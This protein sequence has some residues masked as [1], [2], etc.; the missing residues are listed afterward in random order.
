MIKTSAE[1][2][3]EQAFFQLAYGKLQDSLKNLLP[4]LIGFEIV[5]KNDA[6]TKALGVFGF[7]SQSGEILY[8]PAFFVNGKVKN[9]DLL[10][11]KNNEQ[12]Y[13]LTE[14]FAELFLKDDLVDFGGVSQEPRNKVLQDIPQGDFRQMAVPPRTGKYSVASVID[15]VKDSDNKTKQ[16]FKGLIEKDAEFCEA[17]LRFYPLE[18]VAEALVEQP[19]EKKAEE[20]DLKVVSVQ[21]KDEVAKLTPK[22]KETLLTQGFIVID[23]RPTDKKSKFGVVD[24]IKKF[25]N[26]TESGF[27]PYVTKVGTLNYGLILVRPKQLQ[28]NFATDDA[29][30]INLDAK[31]KGMAYLTD[32]SDVFVKDQIKVDDY[33]QVHKMMV[34]PAEAKPSYSNVYILLNEKMKASQPFRINA[35]F[36][37]A[38]GIRRLSVEPYTCYCHSD[39]ENRKGIKD[40]PGSAHDLPRGN[41]YDHPKKC[42]EFLLVMTKK[43]GDELSYGGKTVYVPAGYKLL[44][45]NIDHHFHTAVSAD[46]A[47]N[48]A[49]VK[50]EAA[51]REE[52]ETGK[53]GRLCDLNAFLR[54]KNVFP[55]TVN[56][57]GSEYFV[58]IAGAK[59][60]YD[61]PIKAKIAMTV[62]YGMD[63]K[64][65]SDLIDNLVP[66]K[67]V[68]GH[69]KLAYTGDMYPQP[70]EE[71][72]YTN[73]MG[74]PTYVG[75]GQE[76][77]LSGEESYTGN[78]AQL[79]LGVMPE[80]QGIDPNYVR[81][82][83][84][85]A[86][87]GQKEIFD[88]QSMSTL[89]KYVGV[90][91]KITEYLP[92]MIEAMDRLGRILFLMHWDTEKFIDMYGR[93]DLPE[94]VE[95][96]TNVFKN[97][98]DLI[99]FLKR[100]SPELSI[101]MN[102]NDALDV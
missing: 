35:N 38:D 91:D 5:K 42:N 20:T 68:N 15:Y 93:G 31:E 28:Q 22:Q 60:R 26:P 7:R 8:V 48:D 32:V 85:L 33:A 63:Y 45:V 49:R 72:P 17:V 87:N 101:N 90:N 40:R 18:K 95:L 43:T 73:E 81:Q 99:I 77:R 1:E 102:T 56:T 69:I 75:I 50:E 6:N 19:E 58:N 47:D 30:V 51:K 44:E 92:S 66:D 25:Q 89:A 57:N 88:V 53:P 71:T 27:Y 97:I 10:Y 34:N 80:I 52:C 79:G 54:D 23:N 12:F 39:W 83:I 82:A 46:D 3:L 96:V 78:P 76:N 86:Q 84:Q 55:M 100:K 14:D 94:L 64:E 61:D 65:A 9:L 29:I 2:S 37:D 62:S 21:D 36:K 70:F 4:F 74:Q 16:A 98:G 11:S 24:Y 67:T 59:K 13:P 41:F